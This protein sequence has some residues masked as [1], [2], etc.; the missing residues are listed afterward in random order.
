ME[1]RK[2]SQPHISVII[3]AYNEEKYILK[4]LQSLANQE[5]KDF[6]TIVVLSGC[7]DRTENVVQRFIKLRPELNVSLIT[8][9]K[10][11]VSRARNKG[12]KFARGNVLFFL[13]ADTFLDYNCLFKVNRYMNSEIAVATCHS[14]PIPRQFLYSLIVGF[15]NMTHRLKLIKGVHGTFICHRGPFE[16]VGGYN[17]DMAIMEHRELVLRLLPMGKYQWIPTSYA[18]TSMRRWERRGVSTM[19]LYWLDQ[20]MKKVFQKDKIAKTYEAI[21]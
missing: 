13:D 8:E 9:P 21:R 14:R 2:R 15:K 20:G 6:E 5:Y 16:K 3:P 17:E 12:A 18:T 7:T 10:L 11:G 19:L 4:T 1:G